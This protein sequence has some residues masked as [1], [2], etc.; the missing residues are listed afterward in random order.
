VSLRNFRRR[1]SGRASVVSDARPTGGAH[2]AVGAG[3]ARAVRVRGAGDG[4]RAFGVPH[5]RV[6]IHGTTAGAGSDQEAVEA[7]LTLIAGGTT[8]L[9][10]GERDRALE[11][12]ANRRS[13]AVSRAGALKERAVVSAR[14][15]DGALPTGG[16]AALQWPWG[17]RVR[18]QKLAGQSPAR[19]VRIALAVAVRAAR[20]T[21]RAQ[22]PMTGQWPRS[23]HECAQ[24]ESRA[25][26]APPDRS[27]PDH[28]RSVARD[29]QLNRRSQGGA[30]LSHERI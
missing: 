19:G 24:H 15:R 23:K 20:L 1:R 29:A 13:G 17:K 22:R 26:I 27:S 8:D 21:R 2:E 5:A 3:D 12:H 30:A 25:P 28:P 9:S 4:T 7:S 18:G 16:S 6:A 10:R 14:A 11:S